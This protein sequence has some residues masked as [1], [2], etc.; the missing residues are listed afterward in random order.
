M[1]L[2]N[3]AT[4]DAPLRLPAKSDGS[5]NSTTFNPAAYQLTVSA[6]G[7]KTS[8][9]HN[10]ILQAQ[11]NSTV[12]ISLEIGASEQKVEVSSSAVLVDTETANNTT[13]LDSQLI[14]VAPQLHPQPA[15]LRLRRRRHHA[16]ARR[17]DPNQ[18]Q[19][20]QMSSNFGMNGGR[21]GNECILI[22]GAPSQAVDWGGL[23]VS[24]LQDSVQEQQL[25]STATTPSMNEGGGGIVTLVTKAGTNRF[26][27][28]AYDYL[29]NSASTPTT[30]TTTR[31]Y[32]RRG[33]F[34]QNQ[35]GGNFGGPILKRNNLF[36]FGGYEGLRQPNTQSTGLITVPTA[37]GAPGDFSQTTT[38]MARSASS[39]TPSPPPLINRRQRQSTLDR[40][41][42]ATTSSR[43]ACSTPSARTSSI[44]SRCPTVPATGPNDLN[45]YYAQGA[46]AT[47]QR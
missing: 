36:F 23:M 44:S 11:T 40:A 5:I 32:I 30:G 16:S 24:P 39:I 4:N 2:N 25:F 12:N 18:R 9:Q 21:T 46:G 34:K 38:P 17:P 22:D 43:P 27:G 10:L 14:A 31:T 29:Q 20:D 7:F 15:E 6:A 42:P 41:L 45:N 13:T 26:H 47:R 35:F 37:A 33:Q 8:I 28:E 1:E 19:L 3:I